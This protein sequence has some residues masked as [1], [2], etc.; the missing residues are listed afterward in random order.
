MEGNS[1][2][3]T[4]WTSLNYAVVDVEGN[5]QQPPDLVEL[6]IVPI[7]GGVIGSAR[8]WMVRPE[9]SIQNFA[10]R[11]HGITNK[12]VADAPAFAEVES[13]VRTALN[14][15]VIVAHNAHVDT[16]VLSRKLPGW[17]PA[18]VF[19]T[20]KLAK[21]FV[22]DQ[23]SYRLGSLVEAFA[24]ADGMP[25]G[26]SPHRATYDALAAARLF[27]HLA[28]H[29]DDQPL[30]LEALRGTSPEGRDDDDSVLF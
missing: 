22:P 16:S 23:V 5:G 10:T 12:D 9:T 24:L 11:I 28:N 30:S 17:V 6:A 15:V 1:R 7:V 20:L 3:M 2:T 14:G 26:L 21:R 13:D 29:T 18:E 27:V 4:D 8:S 25:E 19:D